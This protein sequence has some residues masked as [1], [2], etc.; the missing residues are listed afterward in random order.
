[1]AGVRLRL[2]GAAILL[3]AAACGSTAPGRRAL[4]QNGSS[5]GDLG[6][7]TPSAQNGGLPGGVAS[8]PSGTGAGGSIPGSTGGLLGGGGG[9]L[10]VPGVTSTTIYLG[11]EYS[12]DQGT[13]NAATFGA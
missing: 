11:A 2:A 3:L 7:S 13:A 9:R 1:M 5:E 6:L 10:R 12:L 4:E 8:G